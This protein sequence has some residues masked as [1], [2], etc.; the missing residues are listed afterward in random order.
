MVG[1]SQILN[2]IGKNHNKEKLDK[3]TIVTENKQIEGKCEIFF[4]RQNNHGFSFHCLMVF[5]VM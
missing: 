5:L 3:L 2:K 4:Q 1:I